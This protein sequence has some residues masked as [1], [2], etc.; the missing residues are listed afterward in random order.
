M[1]LVRSAAFP[2]LTPQPPHP[3]G[4]EGRIL[5]L[6]TPGPAYQGSLQ[7]PG[8]EMAPSSESTLSEN[9][10]RDSPNSPE[11]SVR[12]R[13]TH[14]LRHREENPQVPIAARR[15]LLCALVCLFW[16]ILAVETESLFCFSPPHMLYNFVSS[17]RFLL[18]QLPIVCLS[19]RNASCV[20]P[21]TVSWSNCF[22]SS[23]QPFSGSDDQNI[24]TR[25]QC[26]EMGM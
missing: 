26:R 5:K 21:Q 9:R 20:C 11:H 15:A 4:S 17:T 7:A 18:T 3:T 13:S 2:A 14:S 19:Q 6:P 16:N 8:Q 12:S 23:H 10:S 22:V 25:M 1:H 24:C